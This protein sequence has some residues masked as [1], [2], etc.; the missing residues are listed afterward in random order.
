MQLGYV[1]F[2]IDVCIPIDMLLEIQ[3]L[4]MVV[5]LLMSLGRRSQ[6]TR[7]ENEKVIDPFH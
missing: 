4:T 5:F 3:K 2:S 7:L 1:I 6:N